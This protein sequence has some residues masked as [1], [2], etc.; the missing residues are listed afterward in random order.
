MNSVAFFTHTI[1]FPDLKL[2]SFMAYTY[3][4]QGWPPLAQPHDS[5]IAPQPQNSHLVYILT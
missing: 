3:N 2:V 5:P 4:I 1:K